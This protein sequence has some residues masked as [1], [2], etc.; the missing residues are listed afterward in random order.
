MSSLALTPKP[1]NSA[2]RS[3][4]GRRPLRPPIG[5]A[6]GWGWAGGWGPG[7]RGGWAPVAALPGDPVGVLIGDGVGGAGPNPRPFGSADKTA[8]L[9]QRYLQSVQINRRLDTLTSAQFQDDSLPIAQPECSWSSGL[10]G[11]RVNSVDICRGTHVVGTAH[12]I[13]TCS[14]KGSN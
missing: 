11:G 8:E 1:E 6:V 10:G 2:E 7:W 13:H 12:Q 4:P 9:S 5:A 14:T 3:Q